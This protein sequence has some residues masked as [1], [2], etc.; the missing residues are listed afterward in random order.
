MV[1]TLWKK[2]NILPAP[3]FKI[4]TAK[5]VDGRIISKLIL[6]N[7]IGVDFI[8]LLQVRNKRL[9]VANMLLIFDPIKYGEF[10]DWLRKR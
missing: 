5:L 10:L 7:P 9:A 8:R 4:R 3:G 6:R 1:L 2:I